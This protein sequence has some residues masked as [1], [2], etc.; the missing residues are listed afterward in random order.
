[1]ANHAVGTDY[2]LPVQA[3]K[4]LDFDFAVMFAPVRGIEPIVSCDNRCGADA[5]K[6]Q[7]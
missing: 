1:L 6:A 7:C 4:T 3:G 5:G 2:R